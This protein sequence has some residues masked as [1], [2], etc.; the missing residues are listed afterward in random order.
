MRRCLLGV[1]PHPVNLTEPAPPL[2]RG[3]EIAQLANLDIRETIRHIAHTHS[4]Q[5]A[6]I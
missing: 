2:G 4:E 5:P 3:E 1:R 6:Q